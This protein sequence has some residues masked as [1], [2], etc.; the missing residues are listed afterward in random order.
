MSELPAETPVT[1]PPA[2]I[3]ATPVVPLL[4]VP[5]A[6][7]STNVAVEPA[8]IPVEPVITSGTGLTVTVIVNDGPAQEPAVD[9]GITRYSTV[10][11]TVLL[12]F[13]NI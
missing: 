12:E 4:H 2:S 13:V 11:A 6:V 10:P 8:Q 5:P 3:V 9:V 7:R 1:I